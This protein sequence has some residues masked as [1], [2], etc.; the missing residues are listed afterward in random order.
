[1]AL[2][3]VKDKYYEDRCELTDADRCIENINRELLGI[4]EKIKDVFDDLKP[5]RL[6]KKNEIKF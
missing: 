3:N 1:M 2:L 4:F 6:L 5:I